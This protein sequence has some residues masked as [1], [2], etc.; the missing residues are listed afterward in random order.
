MC[1]YLFDE[2]GKPIFF[3]RK[4]GDKGQPGDE[5]EDWADIYGSYRPR[6][7]NSEDAREALWV[8]DEFES[9]EDNTES[10]W[11]PEYVGAGLGL[12]R[13]DPINPQYSLR[14]SV[15]P[16]APFPGEALKWASYVYPDGTT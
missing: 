4:A 15:H 2:E 10:E 16:L 14:H 5:G 3:A 1:R 6:H 7:V 11:D 12:R 13:E 8:T 9:E